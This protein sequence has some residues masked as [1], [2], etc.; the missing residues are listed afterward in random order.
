MEAGGLR[1]APE[2]GH[3]LSPDATVW[4]LKPRVLKRLLFGHLQL[5][6]GGCWS[7]RGVDVE[8]PFCGEACN[9]FVLFEYRWLWAAFES[10][11]DLS[12]IDYCFLIDVGVYG[13]YS[14]GFGHATRDELKH[15]TN[16]DWCQ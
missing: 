8:L 5:D 12:T 9:G 10:I 11:S 7:E 6:R 2:V 16:N 13:R 4:N 15:L 1:A 3:L 14:D